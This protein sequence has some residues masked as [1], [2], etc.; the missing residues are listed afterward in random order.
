M[1]SMVFKKEIANQGRTWLLSF[2]TSSSKDAHHYESVL[3]QVGSSLKGV[4]KVNKPSYGA[5]ILHV[6]AFS[7]P[8]KFFPS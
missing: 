4:V 1:S 2:S 5:I 6:F 3:E 8:D 7:D